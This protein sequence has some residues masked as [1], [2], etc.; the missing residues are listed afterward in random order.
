MR[1]LLLA[2]GVLAAALI[3]V[4]V[5]SATTPLTAFTLVVPKATAHSGL[6]AR[7]ILPTGA[8]CPALAVTV[9]A[10]GTRTDRRIAMTARRPSPRTGAAYSALFVCQ[11]AIPTH[12]VR[13]SVGA[14]TIPAAL[15]DT[16]SRIALLGDTG[17]RLKK[18]DPTQNC[19]SPA[20]WPL[21]R[22]AASVQRAH[23]DLIIH[24]GDY[25]YR[26]MACPSDMLARCG[27]TPAPVP[28]NSFKDTA[29][30]WLA[31]AI[32]PLS[33]LFATAPIVM[34]RGNHEACFRGG[35]GWYLFFDPWFGSARHC[36][37]DATGAV[38]NAVSQ[39]WTQD[40]PIGDGRSL[41]IAVVDSA[42]GDDVAVSSWK[43]HEDPLYATA[44][45][46]SKAAP[47]RESW[48][49]THRPIFGI[50]RWYPDSGDP[51]WTW[52]AADQTAAALPHLDPFSLILGSHIHAAEANQLPGM[53]GQLVVGN[54]G[55]LLESF[56][57]VDAP[58]VGPLRTQDGASMLPGTTLPGNA[59]STWAAVRFGW[60]LATPGAGA[61]VW[62]FSHRTPNGVE[63]ARCELAKRQLSCS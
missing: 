56:S 13:A 5:A 22:L 55:V 38:P 50:S 28:G 45:A 42:Y 19:A 33:P 27:G 51:Y 29:Y 58:A 2:I 44:A 32:V 3:A 20:T 48:L 12:A 1:R 57:G 62:S 37:P 10:D 25:F 52:I 31:D 63:F 17:C 35:N 4:P 54:S 43:Q 40:F 24:I 7:A 59:T 23:P 14:T 49:I 36:A 16:I 34:T 21:G 60:V 11:A 8:R 39:T 30:S 26:E 15:P 9:Q 53:P 46:E 41:H 47:G 61:G 18:G 6:Q